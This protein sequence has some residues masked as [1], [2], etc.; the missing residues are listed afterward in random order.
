M[1]D[2]CSLPIYQDLPSETRCAS[3]CLVGHFALST[4][5]FR[6]GVINPSIR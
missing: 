4:L 3:R 5:Y 1:V 2:S 6:A